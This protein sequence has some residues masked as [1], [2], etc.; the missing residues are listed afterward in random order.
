MA[1][2]VRYATMLGRLVTEARAIGADGVVGIGIEREER[3]L[4]ATPLQTLVA[5]GTAV[6]AIGRVH[7]EIPFTTDLSGAEVGFALRSGWVPMSLLIVPCMA[8]RRMDPFSQSQRRRW[9][10]N[11]EV[12]AYTDLVNTCRS[13]ARKDF[14]AEAR[15]IGADGAVL[16]E[17]DLQ[18]QPVQ[19]EG[20]ATALVTV[21]GTALAGFRPPSKQVTPLTMLRLG[22]NR[23]EF[24]A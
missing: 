14:T 16:S 13:Q 4:G 1:L 2:K 8:I 5:T 3:T 6:R 10:K 21:T 7:A 9:A 12:D 20:S 18:F 22:S 19:T 17:I 24:R 15:R 23:K 11:C